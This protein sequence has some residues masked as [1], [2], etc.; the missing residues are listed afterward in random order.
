MGE[1]LVEQMKLEPAQ[2]HLPIGFLDE[3]PALRGRTIHG[4]PVL[5]G[6]DDLNA[7]ASE[8]RPDTLVIAIASIGRSRV[9]ELEALCRELGLSLGVLPTLSDILNT[10]SSRVEVNPVTEVDLLGRQAMV[11]DEAAIRQLVEGST[12]LVTGAGGSIGFELTRQLS[13]YGPR[14]L[15]LLDRDESALQSTQLALEG[16]GLLDSDDI[17]LADIR[18]APWINE[19]FETVRPQL[20]F[21]AA[22]LKHLPMLERY[23]NEAWKT[24]IVGTRNIISAGQR[25]GVEVLVNISTDKAADPISVLGQTKLVTEFLTWQANECGDSG[26]TQSRFMSVRFGNVLGSRGSVLTIFQR[27]VAN[28]ECVTVTD[29]EVTRY[30]MTIQE[31]VHL[32]LQAAVI[33]K[34]GETLVLDMGDPVQI[35][36]VARQAIA[37]SGRDVPIQFTGL[38]KG[39]KMHEVLVGK[40]ET[41]HAG[42]HPSIVHISRSAEDLE[43]LRDL[44]DYFIEGLGLID[45]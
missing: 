5:G 11:T 35:L 30:F 9:R 4:V 21:H 12:V 6:L 19:V 43:S 20:V 10:A 18:D 2:T 23:P 33:G 17:V 7:I 27:Q 32:V 39:E 41:N 16:H 8:Y 3:D 36:D 14:R 31:A 44:P 24:N 45:D 34:G 22:A 13:R 42:P 15:V 26:A 37:R 38:R 40:K 1:R 28:G 29:P 25:S